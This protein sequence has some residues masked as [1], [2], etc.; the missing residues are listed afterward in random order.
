[1]VKIRLA[2]RGRKKM[3]MF[4]IVVATST[5]PRDG[6]FIEKIGTY[7]P[8]SI[9]ASIVLNNEKAL[10]WL[11]NGAQPTDTTR[12]ILSYRGVMYAKH[13]QVGVNK[14]A[15]TQEEADKKV[16]EWIAAKDS[17]ITGRV[18]TLAKSKADANKAK[19]EA[20]T[21]VNEARAAAQAAK[22]AAEIAA[23]SP[24][25]EAPAA[26]VVAE[27]PAVEEVAE[28]P[29]AE[30]VAESPAAEVVA[31]SPAAEV[32]AEAPAAEVV[33]EAP[34]AEAPAVEAAPEAPAAEVVAEAAPAAEVVA[35]APAVEEEKPAAE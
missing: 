34:V 30:V 7:N 2:R 20:E 12:A 35:E 9:P 18:E 33:A 1:M 11:M 3:A 6:R 5:A 22:Q 31:E 17:K 4:D 23:L 13:L 25:E 10:Q 24:A 21:K 26:E 32:V 19:L 27:A 15:L 8:N 16:A 14:G 29:A 28:T